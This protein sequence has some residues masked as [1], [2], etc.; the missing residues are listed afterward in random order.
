M[1]RWH[2]EA[3]PKCPSS[4]AFAYKDGD[5]WG[6]CFSCGQSSRI[7]YEEGYQQVATK[8][9]TPVTTQYTEYSVEDVLALP[10]RGFKER[11]I[12]KNIAEH[13]GVHI[14]LS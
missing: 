10:I 6:H 4:D 1:S 8:K 2:Y 3:C 7:E 14:R 11:N 9:S 12:R 5:E 13:Y